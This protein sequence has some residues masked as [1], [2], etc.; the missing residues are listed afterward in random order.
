MSVSNSL[1]LK[2]TAMI[3][4]KPFGIQKAEQLTHVDRI[5]AMTNHIWIG[6]CADRSG[7]VCIGTYVT[8]CV[9]TCSGTV[10]LHLS[11]SEAGQ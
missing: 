7:T 3:L 1:E 6:A 5:I 2:Y 9:H 8:A 10:P 11:T 4:Y